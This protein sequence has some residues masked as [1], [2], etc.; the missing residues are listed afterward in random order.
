M[1]YPINPSE[2][3]GIQPLDQRHRSLLFYHDYDGQS[4][5]SPS[6]THRII[7]RIDTKNC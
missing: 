7:G 5:D 2:N 3:P 1:V 6:T 4:N